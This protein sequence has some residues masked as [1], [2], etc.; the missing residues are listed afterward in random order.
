MGQPSKPFKVSRLEVAFMFDVDER[1]ITNW[2]T[3]SE[4]PL[5]VSKIGRRGSSNEYDPQELI[6]WRI[7]QELK[8]LK[9]VSDGVILDA[10]TEKA[11]LTKEQA[12]AAAMKNAVTRGELV[13]LSVLETA[14]SDVSAQINSILDSLPLKIKKR[15]PALS[16]SDIEAIRKEIVK[17]QNVSASVRP[18]FYGTEELDS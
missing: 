6:K 3:R 7:R 10:D 1:T 13:P 8:K 14:L 16:A 17:A 9:V 5:P 18:T 2:Q 11:R 4:D 12:D 15:A